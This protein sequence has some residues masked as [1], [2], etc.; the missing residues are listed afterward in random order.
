MKVWQYI[1]WRLGKYRTKLYI[2]KNG[3]LIRKLLIDY[4]I[5]SQ[6]S[7]SS[8]SPVQISR[9]V[10][11]DSLQPH[12]PQ[13]SRLPYPAPNPGVYPKSCTLSQWCHPT[14]SSSVIPYSSRLQSFPASGSFQM[15]QLFASSWA[16]ASTSV[17]PMDTQDWS[18]LEW[19]GWSPW[20]P[21]DS[22]ES[23]PTP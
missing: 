10:V 18:P 20:S 4:I 22:Q 3:V 11:S 2:F 9:S 19:T 16:S 13:H 17:P 1:Y 14:I 8:I 6:R 12:G 5:C 15:S 21:R 23:S 7:K